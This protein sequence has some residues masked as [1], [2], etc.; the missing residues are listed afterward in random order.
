MNQSLISALGEAWGKIQAYCKEQ[1]SGVSTRDI[2]VRW[3][4][5]VYGW[6]EFGVTPD[7]TAYI[8]HGHHAQSSRAEDADWYF[9]PVHKTAPGS[10]FTKYNRI[11]EVVRDWPLVKRKLEE[12]AAKE[13]GIFNFEV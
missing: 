6:I 7:G 12:A 5:N 1:Y 2:Q 3:K 13:R 10:Q 8:V 4:H 9:H 11:E